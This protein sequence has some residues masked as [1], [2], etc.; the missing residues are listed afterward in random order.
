MADGFD[1]SDDDDFISQLNTQNQAIINSQVI[2][3]WLFV[4]LSDALDEFHFR[5]LEIYFI[6]IAKTASMVIL[7][8][9]QPSKLKALL[10]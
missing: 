10:E 1:D 5:W 2:F 9:I 3:I 6:L 7:F 4:R 8:D